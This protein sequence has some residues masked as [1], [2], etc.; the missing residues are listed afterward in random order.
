VL[1]F[2]LCTAF[3]EERTWAMLE[4]EY[5]DGESQRNLLVD[6][7][8]VQWRQSKKLPPDDMDAL[9]AFYDLMLGPTQVFW[10]YD[11]F[12]VLPHQEI[13]TNWDSTGGNPQGR[14]PVRFDSSFSQTAGVGMATADI[15]LIEVV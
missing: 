10:Y 1:P 2:T 12:D 15:V 9:R 13:G 11:P 3:R 5:R 14:H 7:H 6:D 4:N 8:R